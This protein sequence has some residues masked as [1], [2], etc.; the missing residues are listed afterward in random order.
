M[1]RPAWSLY[2]YQLIEPD[3]QLD[4]FACQ[5][6]RVHLVARQLELGGSADRTLCGTLL[7]AQ[8]R[9][10]GVPSNVYRDRR[11]CPLCRAILEA[12]RKGTRP[13]WPEL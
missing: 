6:I 2:A 13:V 10:S 3:E 9:W 11:L 5:E 4:L 7:P 8:P 1:P 12:Q